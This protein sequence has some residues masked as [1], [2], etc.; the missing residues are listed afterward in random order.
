M[1]GGYKRGQELRN[2]GELRGT[3][4]G[5]IGGA[6]LVGV[7]APAAGHAPRGA[8]QR[9]HGG[10]QGDAGG[11]DASYLGDR[12]RHPGGA[13]DIESARP[14]FVVVVVRARSSS[15]R[16]R[17]PETIPSCL[18]SR[19]IHHHRHQRAHWWNAGRERAASDLCPNR[20][21][22]YLPRCQEEAAAL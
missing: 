12:Q 20:E 10:E 9:G 16:K 4:G 11:G 5:R 13:R 15:S 22:I 21:L 14:R 6:G 18:S 19:P 8:P 7:A 3:Q 2:N 17:S 1:D